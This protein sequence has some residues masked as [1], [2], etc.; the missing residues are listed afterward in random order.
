MLAIHYCS[1]R[2]ETIE[3]LKSLLDEVKSRIHNKKGILADES[4]RVF[5]VNPVADL[6]MMNLLEDC[7]GRLCGTD[8]LILHALDPIPENIPPMKALAS[9][10][11][12]DPMVG[13]SSDRGQRICVDIQTFEAEALI[14]SRI[15]GASHCALEGELIRELINSKLNIP[16]LEIEVPPVCDSMEPTLRTRLEALI[17]TAKQRRPI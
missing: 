8:F 13:S 10:A 2:D 11:L 9:A 12:A 4:V 15:P 6:K 5:W 3:V 14:I 1:D 7:G 16:T 17:E